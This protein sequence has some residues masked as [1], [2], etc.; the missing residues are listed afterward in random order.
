[1]ITGQRDGEYLVEFGESLAISV[2]RETARVLN[3]SGANGLRAVVRTWIKQLDRGAWNRTTVRRSIPRS[4]WPLWRPGVLII[5][6]AS[7]SEAIFERRPRSLRK[8]RGQWPTATLTEYACRRD[9]DDVR[10]RRL[11]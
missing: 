4:P 1:M 9:Q 6:A 11:A 3:F 10:R 7:P 5:T 2:F 8:D